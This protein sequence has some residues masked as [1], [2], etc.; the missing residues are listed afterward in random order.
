M[1]GRESGMPAESDWEAFFDADTA[2]A[3]IFDS[4]IVNGDA[5]EFGCGYGTFTMP[6]ASRTRGRF[7]ALDIEPALIKLVSDKAA[8]L[9]LANVRA[10]IRDFLRTGSGLARAS[11][12][13]AMVFNLLHIDEPLVLLHEIRRILRPGGALSVMHWRSDIPTPRGPSLD[14]RPSPDQC[15][16]WLQGAGFGTI[17]VVDLSDACP[18]HFALVAN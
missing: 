15:S 1:K 6:A 13:H 5:V 14:I 17:R 3:R 7:T 2:I 4:G 10:Q 11:H 16:L 12:A 9:S 8:R 18:Y